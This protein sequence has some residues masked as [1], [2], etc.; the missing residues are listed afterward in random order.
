MR[1]QRSFDVRHVK[2]F[3]NGR[4]QAVRIPRD[5]ELEGDEVL[6]HREGNRLILESIPSMSFTELF[7]KWQPLNEGLPDI[8]DAGPEPVDLF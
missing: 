5:F 1:H 8:P 6:I 4:S 2:L 7:A 3:K